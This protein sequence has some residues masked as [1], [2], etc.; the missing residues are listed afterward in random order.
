[1]GVGVVLKIKRTDAREKWS[2]NKMTEAKNSTE[3][4]L[5]V[6]FA[7]RGN[8]T[9]EFLS[10]AAIHHHVRYTANLQDSSPRTDIQTGNER[11]FN[12]T[13]PSSHKD[14]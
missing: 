11:L 14:P 4:K 5:T 3:T 6:Q 1:M 10:H 9:F 8:F 13:K 2:Q 12:S 7:L